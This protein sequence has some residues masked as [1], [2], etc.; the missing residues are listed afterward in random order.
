MQ[1]VQPVSVNSA[2][3]CRSLEQISQTAFPKERIDL[4]FFDDSVG[5]VGESHQSDILGK[6]APVAQSRGCFV[7]AIK[8]RSLTT[9]DAGGK[10]PGQ[11][12]RAPP[13]L[14]LLLLGPDAPLV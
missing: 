11:D 6:A 9:F 12:W 14:R 3:N 8:E 7:F 1:L 13:R 2:A 5:T 10:W 4:N